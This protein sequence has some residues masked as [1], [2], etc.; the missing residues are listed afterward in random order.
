M[1][2]TA[3]R[4]ASAQWPPKL[5]ILF[6]VGNPDP[7]IVDLRHKM[8]GITLYGVITDIYRETN[9]AAFVFSMK[10]EDA[11][12]V[13]WIRLHFGESWSLRRISV[14]HTVYISGMTSSMSKRMRLELSWFENDPGAH[15]VNIS[16]LPSMLNS[17]CLH[18]LSCLSNMLSGTTSTH[19]CKVWLSQIEECQIEVRETHV[20]CGHFIWKSADGLPECSFCDCKCSSEV[21]NTFLLKITVADEMA[22]VCAW[23]S[24]Q[25]ASELLQITPD[26]FYM[27]PED[28]QL[29]YP[30]SLENEKF[31]VA[32]VNCQKR[33]NGSRRRLPPGIDKIPWEITG[34]S[35]S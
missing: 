16:T 3:V 28:E 14:G 18:R 2:H 30:S 25:T 9:E 23:C 24:G 13:A 15:V 4:S 5:S 17:P 1:T 11:T 27:L 31:T 32:I 10:L 22:K 33:R 6:A 26:E 34:A 7:F 21:V 19:I 35:K 20:R 29:I 8:T 12:G